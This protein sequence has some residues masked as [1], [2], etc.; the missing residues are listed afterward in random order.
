MSWANEL[1][2][3]YELNCNREFDDGEPPMLP[4][5]HTTL[6]T[7][8]QITID[9]DGN[10]QDASPVA[11][12]EEVTII[13]NTGKAK[14]GKYPAPFPL[15][16]CLKY[17]GG[18]LAEYQPDGLGEFSRLNEIY[19]A[20]LESWKN[21]ENTHPSV[22][23]VY[24]Y[25]SRGTLVSDCIQS[26]V[27]ELDENGKLKVKQT[28]DAVERNNIRFIVNYDDTTRE[29]KTW[30]DSTLYDSFI[31]FN[32][33]SM[34]DVQLCYALGK[35]LSAQYCH[36]I[37]ILNRMANAK[38]IS[39]NDES[40][41]SYRGR[42]SEKTEAISISYDFSEKMHT[43]L[44]WLIEK[45]SMNF[46]TMTVIVWASDLKPLP[47]IT[48]SASSLN[49][50]DDEVPSTAPM[51]AEMLRKKIF[52]NRKDFDINTRVM[53]MAIDA[54]SKGRASIAM[55]SELA[56]SEFLENINRWHLN[57]GIMRYGGK[58]PNSFSLYEIVNCAFGTEIEQGGKFVLDVSPKLLRETIL[59][60][61]PCVTEG[62]AIP[63]DIINNLCRKAS[64]P[65]A[66]DKESF[67]HRK[68]LETACG[69]IRKQLIDKGGKISMLYNPDN[70]DRNYLYGCLLAVANAAENAALD[71]E[72]RYVRETSAKKLWSAFSQRPCETWVQ[73]RERLN[74][75]LTKLGKKKVYYERLISEITCKFADEDFL[76][77]SALEPYYLLGYDTFTH[78][79]YTKKENKEDK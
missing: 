78:Y 69:M 28:G 27:L 38:L 50:D 57:T 55:Y 59:R 31:A 32:C 73:I 67:N 24:N 44:K 21:S 48:G 70:T 4:I 23:A 19:L 39:S 62:R 36:P 40:G 10:F 2:K 43:A 76:D 71:D 37:K 58:Q 35:E 46:D 12:G 20:Q 64:N 9:E 29:I 41:F 77:N 1:Y 17:V 74:P 54:A 30:K 8:I 79:I 61:I 34:G 13:P 65:Q 3:I 18:D 14:T 42:F 51:Y 26:G 68:V 22:N 66:Y 16:E 25:V 63:D 56:R 11:K 33:A 6:K 53:V 7:Q 52:G 75:Y 72:D 49:D 47:D 5:A 15:T 45:Q 60:L